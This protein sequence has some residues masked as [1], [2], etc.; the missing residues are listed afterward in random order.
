MSIYRCQRW[1]I[2]FHNTFRQELNSLRIVSL[3]NSGNCKC[4]GLKMIL[5]ILLN[6]I[7]KLVVWWNS[8]PF[9]Y[10]RNNL[11]KNYCLPC[12]VVCYFISKQVNH[13]MVRNKYLGTKKQTQYKIRFLF[14]FHLVSLYSLYYMSNKYRAANVS[15]LLIGRK[16][17]K[18]FYPYGQF[19]VYL[20][21]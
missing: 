6:L 9:H 15:L 19:V 11:T 7:F 10:T 18:G 21:D 13:N 17:A 20:L 4:K 8:L 14:F 2:Q 12:L 16:K 5:K 3:I 1:F